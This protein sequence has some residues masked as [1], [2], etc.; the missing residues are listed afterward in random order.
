MPGTRISSRQRRLNDP[1]INRR[2][3]T[4]VALVP[5][6]WVE[7]HG[8]NQASRRD[9][10]TGLSRRTAARLASLFSASGKQVAPAGKGG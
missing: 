7:T 8:Y 1:G 5:Q 9:V 10:C 3:A 4:L 2:N 6:P